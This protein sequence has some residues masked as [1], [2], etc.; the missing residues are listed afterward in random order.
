MGFISGLPDGF[1]QLDGCVLFFLFFRGGLI[2][3]FNSY[4]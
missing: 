3:S 2:L 1:L 4:S